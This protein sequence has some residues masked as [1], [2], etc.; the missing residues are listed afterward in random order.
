V[1]TICDV[2]SAVEEFIVTARR[3]GNGGDDRSIVIDFEN[4][5]LPLPPCTHRRSTTGN[6]RDGFNKSKTHDKTSGIAWGY[7]AISNAKY[8]GVLLRDVLL[9][10]GL[11]TPDRADGMGAVLAS[12]NSIKTSLN[13]TCPKVEKL[14]SLEDASV[15]TCLPSVHSAV[16]DSV[17][18]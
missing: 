11:L 3:F 6:R 8:G 12:C 17:H 7:G 14:V 1:A 13:F 15:I 10:S 18:G 16:D 2:I 4:T 5:T 9:Y